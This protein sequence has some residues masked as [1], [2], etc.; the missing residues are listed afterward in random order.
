MQDDVRKIVV[1]DKTELDG[2]P[3][4]YIERHKPAADGAITLT[5]DSPDMTP[6]MS[7]A[8]SSRLR[9]EMFLAYNNRAYPANEAV[10]L[11]LLSTRMKIAN[12]LGYKTWADLAT[13]DQM[14]GSAENMRKF[15]NEV[16]EATRA[17]S[18]REYKLLTD[19][20]QSKDPHA[21]PLSQSDTGY[22]GE[23]Y[24]PHRL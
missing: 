3:T 24:R 4:D 14:M 20:V 6:V 11:D 8:K 9:R 7:Y 1:K 12:A 17:R 23:Q 5:T 16:D 15:L 19:F 22:W 18:D 21:L 10:L 2:L 13:A